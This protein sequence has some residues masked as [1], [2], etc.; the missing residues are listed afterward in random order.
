MIISLI[1]GALSIV[2]ALIF[3][4]GVF[5]QIAYLTSY[6]AEKYG[7]KRVTGATD[8]YNTTQGFSDLFLIL[9]VVFVLCTVL[10][11][12]MGCQSRRKYYITNYIAIGIVVVYE[13]VFA[14]I[15]IAYLA[16]VMSVFDTV[17]LENAKYYYERLE[18]PRGTWTTS[19]WMVT[20]GYVFF[21]IVLLDAVALV[22]NLV[23]KL[24]LM[25]GEKELL[26]ASFAKEVA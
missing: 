4:S 14:I 9:G 19:T 17:N 16:E 7:S 26:E 18:S 3:C 5:F 2:Y 6:D 12:V 1:I 22:L 20:L 8:L 24:K 10:L 25:K 21:A 11:F 23:W 15:L 13:I